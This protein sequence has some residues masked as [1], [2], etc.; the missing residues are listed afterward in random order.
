[1]KVRIGFLVTALLFSLAVQ[2]E[3]REL[4]EIFVDKAASE[5]KLEF[6]GGGD[7]PVSNTMVDKSSVYQDRNQ[8]NPT[9]FG[10]GLKF[11]ATEDFSISVEAGGE[12]IDQQALEVDS[13][14][15]V[16]ELSY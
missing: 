3:E 8:V 10:A 1:M 4:G 15:V 5:Q 14:S 12:V 11:N 16:F 6:I 7:R 13:G 9:E 2:A